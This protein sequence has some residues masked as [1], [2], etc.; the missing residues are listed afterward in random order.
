MNRA[1][2]SRAHCRTY[3][4]K[5]IYTKLP[6]TTASHE[7]W[8]TI[9]VSVHCLP[10]VIPLHERSKRGACPVASA[11]WV[12]AQGPT[13]Q[14]RWR[15]ACAF[16]A[17]LLQYGVFCGSCTTCRLWP[18][19]LQLPWGGLLMPSGVLPS[20]HPLRASSLLESF[21]GKRLDR[22]LMEARTCAT[23]LP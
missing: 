10:L 12:C 17:G 5:A 19:L 13:R 20:S 6:W 3:R 22:K 9:T 23:P 11:C 7:L 2:F 15:A 21:S 14:N 1:S 16:A 4:A 8:R 18:L